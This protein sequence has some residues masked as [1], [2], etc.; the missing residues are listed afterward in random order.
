MVDK[1]LMLKNSQ[2]IKNINE[3]SG[4]KAENNKNVFVCLIG[5]NNTYIDD[6]KNMDKRAN[7]KIYN[8]ISS[9]PAMTPDEAAAYGGKYIV[10]M[11]A[12]KDEFGEEFCT[13]MSEVTKLFRSAK[14]NVSASIEKN[15]IMKLM[16]WY[17]ETASDIIRSKDP[18]A[19]IVGINADKLQEYLFYYML[20]L[21][22]ANVLILNGKEDL[23]I[24]LRRLELSSVTVLG[25]LGN[26]KIP[27]FTRTVMN[28]A[29][30]PRY[31]TG[32]A[33]IIPDGQTSS[34]HRQTIQ[35]AGTNTTRPTRTSSAPQPTPQS[36]VVIPQRPARTSS[37]PQPS[38][39]SRVVIPP[40]PAR[41]SS[42]PQPTPQSRVVVPPRPAR[43]SFA[44]QPTPQRHNAPEQNYYNSDQNSSAGYR[45]NMS[46]PVRA[47]KSYEELARL[48]SSVVQ[49]FGIRRSSERF[50]SEEEFEIVGS[51]S[52]IMIA[53]NGYILTNFHVA[54]QTQEYIVRVENDSNVYR[55]NQLIKYHSGYDLA[56]IRIDRKLRPLPIYRGPKALVRGQKVV[57]IGSPKGLFNTVSDGIISGFRDF[58]EV[59]M[60]QFT[61]PIS[62]GSSG[63]ALINMY[64]ELIG[65]STAGIDEGQNIN[66]AV[67]CNTIIN[68]AGG[69]I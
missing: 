24:G 52:G 50:T 45:P 68:F 32:G 69:I 37:V 41:T 14:G 8:R 48:A 46:S 63:G 27:D 64:G 29:Y 38:P 55:T 31:R 40:R 49:I 6:I 44:P 42:V 67:D 25:H 28:T 47:E 61:A 59:R 16:F 51:G 34:A 12:A 60:I 33:R 57:A 36:R 13:A 2:K 30:Q 39:Q 17:D 20:A 11:N 66:F 3:F 65:I 23:D 7:M 5:E 53:E 21:L 54:K 10:Y 19:K 18:N 43:T 9:L 4:Y 62:N 1:S 58:E 56:I 26:S 22:G 15:F 35:N